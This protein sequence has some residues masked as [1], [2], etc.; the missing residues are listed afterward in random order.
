MRKISKEEFIKRSNEKYNNKFDYSKINF[1][2]Y[3]TPVKII[4][5]K[6]GEFE[7]SPEKHLIKSKLGCVMCAK[8]QAKETVRIKK[9]V[10]FL[11]KAKKLFPDLNYSKATYITS[12]KKIIITCPT[13]GDFE[14]IP[15]TF[16]K[17]GCPECKKYT[18]LVLEK[19]KI[20]YIKNPI[21]LSNKE[22]VIG[23]VYLFRNKV[24]NKIYIGKTIGN[25]NT[26]FSTHKR[27]IKSKINT[28]FYSALRKYG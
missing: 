10:E 4:C 7:Y 13:H 3:Y 16:L 18:P 6:H 23:S 14:Q 20:A 24:N 9:E 2:D 26:R 11:T 22:S 28:Y 25:Y 1:T 15:T 17:I 19:N 8:E 5:P 12:N 27:N 21:K